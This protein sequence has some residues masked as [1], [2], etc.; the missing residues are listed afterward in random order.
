MFSLIYGFVQHVCKQDEFHVLILGLDKA[1][2]TN[3]LEKL[4]TL[5]SDLNGKQEDSGA[6]GE[7]MQRACVGHDRLKTTTTSRAGNMCCHQPVGLASS[8][9]SVCPCSSLRATRATLLTHTT[10][11]LISFP[12]T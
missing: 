9:L 6:W 5:L 12:A 8:Q 7:E 2:K 10:Q 1:G 11:G 3:V 4:K